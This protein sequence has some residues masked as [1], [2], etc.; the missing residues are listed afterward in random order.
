MRIGL[1]HVVNVAR[2]VFM[3][4][5][6]TSIF[7]CIKHYHIIMFTLIFEMSIFKDLSICIISRLGLWLLVL[8][9]S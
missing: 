8:V 1:L 2:D 7:I 6:K 5:N 4:H 9:S 3:S